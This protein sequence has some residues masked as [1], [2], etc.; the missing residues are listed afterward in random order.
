MRAK[1]VFENISFERDQDIKKAMGLGIKMDIQEMHFWQPEYGFN[2]MD[3]YHVKKGIHDEIIE[4]RLQNWDKT[5]EDDIIIGTDPDGNY[6][7]ILAPELKGH[8]VTFNDK[9]YHL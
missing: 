6:I 9:I 2:K 3:H 8:N 1:K 4:K 5:G 7:K